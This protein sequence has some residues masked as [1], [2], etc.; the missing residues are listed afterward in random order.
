MKNV[1]PTSKEAYT[2]TDLTTQREQVAEYLLQRTFAGLPTSDKDVER[3]T[4]IPANRVSARRDELF[5]TRYFAHGVW[6]IPAQMAN[7]YDRQTQCTVQTWS[8]VI[9]IEGGNLLDMKRDTLN[10]IT[11]YKMK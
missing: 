6:W 7:R 9:W 3:A 5:E 10:F 11:N 1:T 2:T 4:G 8:M